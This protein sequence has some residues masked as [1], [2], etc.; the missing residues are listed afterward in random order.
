M[1]MENTDKIY[2]FI[3]PHHNCPNL[4]YRLLDTIP[5]REDIE[6]IVVDDNSDVDKV[7]IINRS[8][9]QLFSIPASESK[10]AGHARNV[11]LD[12]ATGKWLLFADS[13][14]YYEKNVISVLDNFIDSNNDIIYFNYYVKNESSRR[15]SWWNDLIFSIY[16]SSN[17]TK[18]DI[19]RLGLSSNVPWNK[20]FNHNFIKQ[21]RVRF[22]EIPMGNDAWFVNYAGYCAETATVID[23]ILYNYL[24]IQNGITQSKRPLEHHKLVIKSDKKRNKLKMQA[25]CYDILLTPGF[26]KSIVIRDFGKTTYYALF[27]KRILTELPFTIAAIRAFLRKINI[28]KKINYETVN[29]STNL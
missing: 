8:D 28:I 21:N 9:V 4:L 17:K 6:I 26:N 22:E 1:N 29:N 19:Q 12:H 24:Q 25:K 16:K 3:I 20:M 14:D 10:G 2:S 5:M 18:R 7:P 23:D 27:L 13:D 11:G 15:T